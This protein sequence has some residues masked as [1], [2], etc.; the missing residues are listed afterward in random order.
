MVYAF[1]ATSNEHGQNGDNRHNRHE[2]D[3]REPAPDTS[4]TL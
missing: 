4:I 2:F 1:E 3:E